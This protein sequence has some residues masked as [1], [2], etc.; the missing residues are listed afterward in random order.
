M[1]I[2]NP[3]QSADLYFM[4]SFKPLLHFRY[5]CLFFKAIK[6]K[7]LAYIQ[8]FLNI[9]SLR[10]VQFHSIDGSNHM[11][12][13]AFYMKSLIMHFVMLVRIERRVF[14]TRCQGRNYH[15]L[16]KQNQRERERERE[17]ER[18]REREKKKKKKKDWNQI[19]L[20]LIIAHDSFNIF[21]ETVQSK[22]EGDASRPS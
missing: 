13:I 20:L 10:D 8:R 18:K 21:L 6:S 12:L 11:I 19:Q 5:Q 3:L 4:D 9:Y 16:K 7:W 14:D 17:R 15:F 22:S 1:E 2:S